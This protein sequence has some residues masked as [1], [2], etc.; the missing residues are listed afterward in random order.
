[1]KRV[2]LLLAI[3]ALVGGCQEPTQPPSLRLEKSDAAVVRVV[4]PT[5]DPAVDIPNIRAAIAAATPRAVIQFA[6][7]TYAIGDPRETQFVVSAPGVTLQGDRRGTT[8]RGVQ[9]DADNPD[10]WLCCAL[11]SGTFLLNGGHQTVR[12]LTFDGYVWAISIGAPG[13]QTGGYRVENSTFR[14]GFV[15]VDFAGWSEEATTVE[16]N[17]FENVTAPLFILGKTLKIRR[18][19]ITITDPARLTFGQPAQGIIFF[20]E[21]LSGGT[22]CENNVVEEN[23]VVRYNEAVLFLLFD[24][25]WLCRN[26][27]IRNNEVID[28]RIYNTIFIDNGTMVWFVAPGQYQGNILKDNVLRR[29]EGVGL[30]L[31]AGSGN[32]IVG[33]EFHDLPGLKSTWSGYPGTAIILGAPT[34][35]NRVRGNEFENVVNTIV[36]LG[37]DNRIQKDRET[38]S[39]ALVSPRISAPVASASTENPRLRLFRGMFKN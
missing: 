22:V 35:G 25:S 23:T 27:V 8:L 12:R 33:N 20:P 21:F 30:V 19:L 7:G 31:D 38:S 15:G 39:A 24:P 37:T 34:S 11:L 26:N 1:M 6:H 18:N 14:D 3:A 29:S 5:G 2:P 32:Q 4:A 10:D 16:G 28:A 9:L 17:T 13:T 36:D